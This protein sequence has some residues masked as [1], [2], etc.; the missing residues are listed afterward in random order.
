MKTPETFVVFFVIKKFSPLCQGWTFLLLKFSFFIRRESSISFL[1]FC[2]SFLRHQKRG[3]GRQA[4]NE[5]NLWIA[6]IIDVG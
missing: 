2:Y 6:L 1:F 3:G 5:L 4:F